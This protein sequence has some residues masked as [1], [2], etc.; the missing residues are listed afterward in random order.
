M[1]VFQTNTKTPMKEQAAY[2]QGYDEGFTAGFLEGVQSGFAEGFD[3]ATRA[4]M[5]VGF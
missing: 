5:E 1:N 2:S 3:E 4:V